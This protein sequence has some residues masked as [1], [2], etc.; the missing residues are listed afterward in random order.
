MEKR[1]GQPCQD[2]CGQFQEDV[3][4]PEGVK[5]HAAEKRRAKDKDDLD[6]RKI[7]ELP[8]NTKLRGVKQVNEEK[9]DVTL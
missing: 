6:E 8:E 4:R 3:P 1:K 2:R 5:D 9:N 7:V